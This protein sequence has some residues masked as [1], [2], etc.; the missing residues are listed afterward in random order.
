MRLNKVGDTLVEVMLA[1]AVLSM[2]MA[3]VFTLTNR[4]TRLNQTANERTVVSNF[5]QRE[6][7]LLRAKHK[8]Q[9]V[10]FWATL[11]DTTTPDEAKFVS[12][13]NTNF[14]DPVD[15]AQPADG[16][17]Y[18]SK[19]DLSMKEAKFESGTF[20]DAG[21]DEADSTHDLYDIWIEA[22]DGPTSTYAD[23]FIFACWEGIGG[24]VMQSSGIVLRLSR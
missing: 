2:V 8:T 16:S 19:K 18:M 6:A 22:V 3:G 24:E 12:A 21:E 23:F 1:T 17:F 13:I 9:S 7:E 4:A 14:C 10:E 15:G 20:I 11:E 5:M